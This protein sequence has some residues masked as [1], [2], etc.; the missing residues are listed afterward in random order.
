MR[1]PTSWFYNYNRRRTYTD[2]SPTSKVAMLSILLAC[3]ALTL[4][5]LFD[6]S[7]CRVASAAA[8]R[9]PEVTSDWTILAPSSRYQTSFVTSTNNSLVRVIA[10]PTTDVP[11][12]AIEYRLPAPADFA[13]SRNI[14]VYD[15]D[16]SVS[17]GARNDSSSRLGLGV[18]HAI[19]FDWG[20]PGDALNLTSI[21]YSTGGNEIGS[22]P[23]PYTTLMRF[24]GGS[25]C[26]TPNDNLLCAF[27]EWQN[28]TT[29]DTRGELRQMNYR[30]I[31]DNAHMYP[32]RVRSSFGTVEYEPRFVNARISVPTGAS[33]RPPT[34]LVLVVSATGFSLFHPKLSV[35]ELDCPPSSSTTQSTIG[36]S[37]PTERDTASSDAERVQLPDTTASTRRNT[38]TLSDAKI[39]TDSVATPPSSRRDTDTPSNVKITTDSVATTS[40]PMAPS[41]LDSAHQRTVDSISQ[42]IATANQEAQIASFVTYTVG[43]LVIVFVCI[44]GAMRVQKSE[45]WKKWYNANVSRQVTRAATASQIYGP[46][47]FAT[48]PPTVV[49]EQLPPTSVYASVTPI[50]E[51]KTYDSPTSPFVN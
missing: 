29:P 36:T 18:W 24:T 22:V 39:T 19:G 38:D 30:F 42:R 1:V 37:A 45:S 51:Q 43:I 14:W 35:V 47:T 31:L 44:F 9:A 21:R 7:T 17:Q 34:R 40:P 50:S 25:D 6:E 49:Y 12:A 8:L 16:Y 27:V 28:K 4:A 2:V 41:S 11:F 33:R 3:A 13:L 46:I 20:A 5:Q 32:T 10:A 23:R 15:V 48:D 26:E